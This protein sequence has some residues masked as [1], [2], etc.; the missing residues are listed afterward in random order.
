MH[1]REYCGACCIAPSISSPVPGMPRGKPGGVPCIHLSSDYR[2]KIFDDPERPK[3]CD[4]FK[5][6]PEVCG[7][8]REEALMLLGKLEQGLP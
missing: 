2:C 6:E 3:V 8:T 5:A 7:T 4:Q 1:C